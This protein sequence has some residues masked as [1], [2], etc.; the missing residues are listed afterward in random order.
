[1]FA[2]GAG[3]LSGCN[4]NDEG[5]HHFD[6]KLFI[7][8]T[9][10]VSTLTF[11]T[12]EGE[13]TETRQLTVT[14]AL[15]AENDITGKF[16]KNASFTDY[17]NMAYDDNA[18]PLPDEMCVIEQ[19]NV[20]ITRGNIKSETV[21][22]KFTGLEKLDKEQ[23]Y[24]MPIELTDVTGIDVLDSKD[25]AYFVFKGASLINVVAGMN[26]NWAWP[27]WKNPEEFNGLGQF[28]FEALVYGNA[29]KK[30][31]STIMGIESVFLLRIGD[32]N[33]A[34][35]EI[36]I[37]G[38]DTDK[39]TEVKI[40]SGVLLDSKRWYH[41]AV[42]FDAGQVTLYVDGKKRKSEAF[43]EVKSIDL[44]VEHSDEADGKP[45]CFWVGYSYNQDRYLDGM[46]S[47]V[48][49][50]KKALTE[51]D[52]NEENHFY[53]I[54]PNAE[55]LAAYWKFDDATGKVVKD[56]TSNGN[57]LTAAKSLN[58]INVELPEKKN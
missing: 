15:Q 57:D 48:R 27:E 33:L 46:I 39:A 42:V 28:T 50:W 44:G 11:Q 13:V 2:I 53:S 58:W 35:N 7:D 29:F 56:H 36:Q 23:R 5:K 54:K 10:P 32:A 30:E 40:N 4:G 19:P 38:K 45:R 1:M 49:I 24:V 43:G 16:V 41:I 37:A 14:T 21:E 6:N 3:L 34:H 25:K 17:Y 18:Q 51:E 9:N 31:I 8:V 20:T 22:I 12:E 47:E 26:E 55:G 52:I